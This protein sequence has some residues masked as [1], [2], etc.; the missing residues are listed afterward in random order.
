M[1]TMAPDMTTWTPQQRAFYESQ[2]RGAA[3][4]SFGG[5]SLASLL[6]GSTAAPAGSALAG[7]QDRFGG[8]GNTGGGGFLGGLAPKSWG[9]GVGGSWGMGSGGLGTLAWNPTMTD[10]GRPALADMG[11]GRGGRGLG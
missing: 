6:T 1:T 9:F 5:S 3:G 11:V 2:M 10:T 8:G 4:G 7:L